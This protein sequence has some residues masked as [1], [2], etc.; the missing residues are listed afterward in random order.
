MAMAGTGAICIWNDIAPEG[1][2]EFYD[3]HM[4]EHM[5]E[6]AAIP[7]FLRSRR[8]I[9]ID[10]ATRPEFFTLYETADPSVHTGAAYL[11]RLDAP[12]PW[13][14]QATRAFRN[15]SR[16][17]TSVLHSAGR[18]TGGALCTLR[19]AVPAGMEDEAARRIPEEFLPWAAGRAGVAAA[20]LCAT[21]GTAS[22]SE[23]TESRG[24]TDILAAPD[25]VVLIEGCDESHLRDAA[26]TFA[27]LANGGLV[28]RI[29]AGFYRLEF[30][31]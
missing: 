3:W 24:R 4:R 19:F 8:F 28:A 21:D 10:G 13:T 17:L 29:A 27:D 11:A 25:W 31:L 2:A 6:R 30:A 18:G 12:T 9:A 15:T 5:P 26:G 22:R 7:G 16:A 23:T 1:R 20:H 14:K